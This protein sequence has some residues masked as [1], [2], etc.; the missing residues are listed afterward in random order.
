MSINPKIQIVVAGMHH[1]PTELY[2]SLNKHPSVKILWDDPYPIMAYSDS[3]VVASGT[4][5]L[6]VA[7]FETP[8]IVMYKIAP[9]S[10]WLAKMIISIED[11]AM[12]NLIYGN[13]LI[14]EL[15]QEDATPE[16]IARWLIDLLED[17]TLRINMIQGLKEIKSKLGEPGATDRIAQD[18]LS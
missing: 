11:I 7:Y 17:N 14:P 2:S 15:I 13:R 3:V 5:S 9:V 4:A 12:P 18:I 10:Y 16:L 8:M 6:E 1:L